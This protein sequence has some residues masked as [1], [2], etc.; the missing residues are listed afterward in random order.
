MFLN[1]LNNK[2][3]DEF[4]NLLVNVAKVDGDFSDNEKS[5]INAY[6]LEMGLSLK[7]FDD[8]KKSSKEIVQDFKSSS[9]EV[10]KAVFIET[11]ALVL[12][13]GV[14]KSEIG[15]LEQ[16]KD[17]FGLDS[18]FTNKAI[19]WFKEI[20]PIY[21]KGFELIGMKGGYQDE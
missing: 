9:K 16:L 3:R 4:L 18:E 12:I 14:K 2:E 13:D 10:Q 8:Y 17:A 7:K 15:V 11:L 21:M 19:N 5:R 6:V 20:N 1:I